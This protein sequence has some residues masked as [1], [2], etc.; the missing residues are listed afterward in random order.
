MVRREVTL[1]TD[2]V[3]DWDVWSAL[4]ELTQN[5]LDAGTLGDDAHINSSSIEENNNYIEFINEGIK[6]EQKSLLLGATTKKADNTKIGQFGEGYKLAVLVLLRS[7]ARV[8]IHNMLAEEVWIPKIVK[9]KVYDADI[10]AFDIE[11]DTERR[12]S[13]AEGERSGLYIEVYN[14][15]D[16]DIEVFNQNTLFTNEPGY[17]VVTDGYGTILTS[18]ENRGKVYMGGLYIMSDYDLAYGYDLPV[19]AFKI[20]RDRNIVGGSDLRRSTALALMHSSLPIDFIAHQILNKHADDM[21]ALG[22]YSVREEMPEDRLADLIDELLRVLLA[23][24]E[25][26]RKSYLITYNSCDENMLRLNRDLIGKYMLNNVGDYLI[27]TASYQSYIRGLK[28]ETEEKMMSRN[29]QDDRYG[30]LRIWLAKRNLGAED[31]HN[32]LTAIKQ[33]A[34]TLDIVAAS[35][36]EEAMQARI[37]YLEDIKPKE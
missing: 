15:S 32:L 13:L 12:R 11:E 16:E 25:S 30:E 31:E 9:S 4:R 34:P 26:G 33:F 22:S 10:L 21:N 3:Q 18:K 20:G 19:G 5:T 37:D 36:N 1:T 27:G 24:D 35:S 2:Y 6:L 17:T 8:I 29:G 7:G 23:P 14:I 28:K